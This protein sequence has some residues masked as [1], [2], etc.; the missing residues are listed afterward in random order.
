M[1]ALLSFAYALLTKD[2]FAAALTVGLDPYAGFYHQ[3]RHGKPS[4]ALDLME[5][6][7]SIIADSVVLTLVNNRTLLPGDFLTWGEA[8]QLTESGRKKFLAAYEQ[9]K[10]TLVTHPLYGYRM[11]RTR[12]MLKRPGPNARGL[13][14]RRTCRGTTSA[15]RFGEPEANPLASLTKAS[16]AVETRDMSVAS[17][18][19]A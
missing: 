9:R 1:N 13:P 5:E 6:F 14:A 3:G 17:Y 2:A 8:C 15:S 10:S 12:G 11:R 19:V 4:L 18:V 7:R 16:D